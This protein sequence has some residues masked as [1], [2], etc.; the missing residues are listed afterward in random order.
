MDDW[1]NIADTLEGEDKKEFIEGMKA[2]QKASSLS[3]AVR[4]LSKNQSRRNRKGLIY[5]LIIFLTSLVLVFTRELFS[6]EVNQIIL[7]A[8]AIVIAFSIWKIKDNSY[9]GSAAKEVMED[10][11]IYVKHKQYKLAIERMEQAL[12]YS[13]SLN[14]I[15]GKKLEE[16]TSLYKKHLEDLR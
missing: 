8:A 10:V 13:P 1:R 15:I 9:Y 4:E 6:Y 14:N 16:V 2:L 5:V 11:D 3:A 7:F 12:L